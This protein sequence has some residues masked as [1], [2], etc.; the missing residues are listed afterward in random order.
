MAAL[1]PQ[2]TPSEPHEAQ[3]VLAMPVLGAASWPPLRLAPPLPRHTLPLS[4]PNPKQ[5]ALEKQ[6]P[7]FTESAARLT[8]KLG[9]AADEGR[10]VD[11]W[12]SLGEMT[13]DV[14][15]TAAFG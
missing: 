4:A 13:L 12:R 11:V 10:E 14:V 3:G 9:E 15:G 7:L 6:L 1:L 2:G 5:D 8:S